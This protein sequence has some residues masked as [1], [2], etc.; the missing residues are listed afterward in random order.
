M[1]GRGVRSDMHMRGGVGAANTHHTGAHCGPG[2]GP[3]QKKICPRISGVG[4]GIKALSSPL[5]TISE[6]STSR[7]F[8]NRHKL[9]SLAATDFFKNTSLYQLFRD[10]I[11]TIH[12]TT[13]LDAQ[14][15]PPTP[16]GLH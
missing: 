3:A 6:P 14:H 5:G 10:R 16:T 9:R 12:L 2:H 4:N 15:V 7:C 11:S 8:L 13:H 1:P